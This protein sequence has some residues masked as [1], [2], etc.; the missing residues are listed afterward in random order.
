MAK[1]DTRL[2]HYL[3][4][5]RTTAGVSQQALAR[6]LGLASGQS[7][8]NIERGLSRLPPR[9]YDAISRILGVPK[10][11]LVDIALDE[12]RAETAES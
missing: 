6:E 2:G 7:I 3:K 8:S 9:H 4:Q 1:S 10:D 5:I 12:R 11:D